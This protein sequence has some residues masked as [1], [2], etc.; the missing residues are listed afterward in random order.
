MYGN[1]DQAVI[2]HI[3]S[4][5]V[6]VGS[7]PGGFSAAIAAARLGVNVV[8]V[9][10]LG[11]V[12]GQLASGLPMLAF[13]DMHQRQV[14]GGI[15]QEF[16]SRM[17]ALDASAGHR[18]CPFHLST[19]TLDPSYAKIVCFQMID[20]EKNITLLLHTE[21]TDVTV[22]NGK[23]TS[24]SVTGKGHHIILDGKVFIDGTGDGDLAF[25]AG[26]AY[27]KGQEKTGEL[28]P[29]SLMFNL[30]DVDTDEFITWIRKHPEEL[31]YGMGL[32]HIKPGYDADFFASNP[33]FIFFGLEATIKKLR[34]E[35]K[36]PVDRDT[37][38][39]IKLPV[40]GQVAVNT[41]RIL[42]FDGS[43]IHDLSKGEVK[44]HLTVLPLMKM[45]KENV[46]GFEHC[47][48]LSINPVI[49][50]RESRRIM[51]IKKFTYKDAISG[52]IPPDA[53]GLLSYFIDIH[54]GSGDKT[55]T[56][57]IKEP[58]GVPY[59]C[60]VARDI[61]SLMMAGRCI[62]VDAIAFGS[63]R[64]MPLCMAVGQGAGV[65]AALA[66]KEHI[67]PRAVDPQ[68]VRKVLIDQG[69]ILSVKKV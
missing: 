60:T 15:A 18:Y 27:E 43:D 13:L 50:V 54:S 21:L 1:D 26:A 35:G 49:G 29:P 12:G 61:D 19:T 10:R 48:L 8:L 63:T 37:L 31:P 28:Q 51:G 42:N 30:G 5:V 23:V 39:F 40:K 22:K 32:T 55:H 36:C 14:V 44:A 16:V 24:I 52:I 38:I 7:G 59:G 25:M 9:E 57:S 68:D 4:D 67:Q 33:G 34:S 17:V 65:G 6:V 3:Q 56:E 11:Y 20:E 64:V 41:I 45:L 47:V 66:I 58:Y 2:E 62:S 46:P 69:A 53:I